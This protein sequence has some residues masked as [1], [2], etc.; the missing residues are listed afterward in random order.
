MVL[1]EPYYDSYRPAPGHGRRGAARGD[2]AR[3]D[4]VRLEAEPRGR[5][6][7]AHAGAA[8]ELA[9]QPD[10]A[11]SSRRAELEALAALCRERDD[12]LAITDEVYE[13]LVFDGA[14]VPLATLPGMRERTVT[15]SSTG[16]TFTLTGW[17]IGW[18][19]GAAGR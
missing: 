13:H 17:K 14:H 5:D 1:F 3:A 11:R 18:A 7:P 2:P 6:R 19:C 15:I 4:D 8:P 12:L 10:R 16:K 9:A